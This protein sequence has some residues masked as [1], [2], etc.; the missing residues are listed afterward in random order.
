MRI[1]AE[2]RKRKK[3]L[4]HPRM[5]SYSKSLSYP[6]IIRVASDFTG[7]NSL[8]RFAPNDI[9]STLTG[10]FETGEIVLPASLRGKNPSLG[11][12]C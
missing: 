9:G 2:A 5:Y 10:V 1:F 6:G 7:W 11:C 4:C 12:I 3:V 8:E